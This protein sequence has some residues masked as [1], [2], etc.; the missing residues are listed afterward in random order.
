MTDKL[1]HVAWVGVFG[2]IAWAVHNG[3]FPNARRAVRWEPNR[4]A[5]CAL[6]RSEARRIRP[7]LGEHDRLLLVPAE[8]VIPV[9]RDGMGHLVFEPVTGGE[10]G[11]P[12]GSYC[13]LP[14]PYA[15]GKCIISAPSRTSWK[16]RAARLAEALGGKYVGRSRGY[17]IGP[18]SAERFVKL[19]AEGWDG[20]LWGALEPPRAC[21]EA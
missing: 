12:D 1:Y 5:A 15:K 17:T 20:S 4:Y 13:I 9:I 18:K 2:K 21:S 6:S 3:W 10:D 19:Y 14:A 8:Q 7:E 16:T 11:T